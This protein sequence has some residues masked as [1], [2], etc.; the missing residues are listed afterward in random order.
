MKFFEKSLL[1]INLVCL[2]SMGC[3][4]NAKSWDLAGDWSD[5]ENPNGTWSYEV[6][7]AGFDT[8]VSTLATQSGEVA[9]GETDVSNLRLGTFNLPSTY[10]FRNLT[11]IPCPGC[12]LTRSMVAAAHGDINAGFHYNRLGPLVLAYVLLQLM[13]RVVWLAIPSSP[14]LIAR[15]GGYLNRGIVILCALFLINWIPTLFSHF[16]AT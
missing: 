10:S 8:K 5:T 12:G 6:P 14:R 7:G 15:F 4:V 1:F 9:V 16:S 11:G 13:Y 3:Q 2:L